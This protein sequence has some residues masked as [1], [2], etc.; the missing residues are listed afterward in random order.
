MTTN[1]FLNTIYDVLANNFISN[2]DRNI[3]IELIDY[4]DL[5]EKAIVFLNDNGT[6]FKLKL[7]KE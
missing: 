1:E 5:D 2:N 6:H 3:I 7:V 4:V